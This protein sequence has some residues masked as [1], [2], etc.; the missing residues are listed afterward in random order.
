MKNSSDASILPG[1]SE[2][3]LKLKS[4]ALHGVILDVLLLWVD[5]QRRTVPENIWKQRTLTHF[6]KDEITNAKNVLWEISNESTLGRNITRKGESKSVS[7]IDDI[8]GALKI[9][10]EKQIMPTFIGT[11][12]MIL[13]SPSDDSIGVKN[14]SLELKLDSVE[15]SLNNQAKIHLES[16]RKNHDK[17]ISKTDIT[18][19]KI[20]ELRD[21]VQQVETKLQNRECGNVTSTGVQHPG[22]ISENRGG[23]IHNRSIQNENPWQLVGGKGKQRKRNNPGTWISR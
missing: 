23:I 15:K 21:K 2:S 4:F 17:L 3:V 11:S 6:T 10:S 5:T 12:T 19:K 16:S 14:Q 8:C 18:H 1:L 13:Q 22:F 20:D 9:L 7:E